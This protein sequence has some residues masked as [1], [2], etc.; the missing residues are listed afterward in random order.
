MRGIPSTVTIQPP[1]MPSRLKLPVDIH[2][3]ETFP[4]PST[5]SPDKLETARILLMH[6]VGGIFDGCG[7]SYA[8]AYTEQWLTHA[9]ALGAYHG[10]VVGKII[11][12]KAAWE[13]YLN[14][15]GLPDWPEHLH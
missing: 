4:P 11:D 9:K 15:N 1:L 12:L 6:S 5:E 3:A 10:N 14:I 8:N 7:N 13:T 2:V